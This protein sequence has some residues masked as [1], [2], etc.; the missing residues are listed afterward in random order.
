MD[1]LISNKL[2]MYKAVLEVCK[3]HEASWTGIPGFVSTVEELETALK[4]LDEFAGLQSSKTVGVSA[5]K[6]EK[7]KQLVEILLLVQPALEI[8]GKSIG[9]L[10]LQYRNRVTKSKITRLSIPKLVVHVNNVEEDLNSFGLALLPM[11]ITSSILNAAYAII[12]EAR[13]AGSR[14]RM[15]IIERK[16]Y[17]SSMKEHVKLIDEIV[18][19]RL[20]KM[21]RLFKTSIPSF[22]NLYFN[23]RTIIDVSHKKPN[24]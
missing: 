16:L 18:G 24:Q 15:A 6:E 10:E 19:F 2:N 1:K 3:S 8:Y 11:G 17:T 7:R 13:I 20:D 14:P 22:Y 5:L 12:E 21:I 9:D 23:A 4:E